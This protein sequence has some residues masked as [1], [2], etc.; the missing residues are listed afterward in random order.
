MDDSGFKICPFC[1]E[2]IR[3]TA[4]KCR[5]CAEWLEAPPEK[6]ASKQVEAPVDS[7]NSMPS[8]DVTPQISASRAMTPDDSPSFVSGVQ[9]DDERYMPP[10]MRTCK[11]LPGDDAPVPSDVCSSQRTGSE[12]EL[13]RQEQQAVVSVAGS[14]VTAEVDTGTLSMGVDEPMVPRRASYFARHWRGEL[15][16][17]TSYWVNCFLLTLFLRGLLEGLSLVIRDAG[18]MAIA[19]FMIG[20]YFLLTCISVWQIVGTWRSATTSESRGWAT[21][22]EILMV[23]YA[24]GAVSQIIGTVAPQ[25]TEY[26]RILAGDT[27]MPPCDIQMFPNGMDIELRG[28]LRAGS[29]KKFAGALARAPQVRVLYINSVGG[30]VSEAEQMAQLV[31]E[32]RL[33]TYALE[34]C[35]SAA[36]I[37]FLAGKERVVGP[38]TRMGFHRGDFPGLKPEDQI[39]L[40]THE[41]ERLRSAGVEEWFIARVLETPPESMWYPTFDELLRARVATSQLLKP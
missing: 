2:K 3:A 7:A 26:C 19:A 36:T 37:V 20:A 23:V 40:E 9:S 32:R 35:L 41:C 12:T 18:L 22:V 21:I 4:I 8:A 24:L 11:S 6:N 38:G 15:P 13:R 10:D 1:R 34:Q 30:R 14:S 25:V 27:S 33:T 28:G 5:Y 31:K 39:S 29:A 16:L 17:R